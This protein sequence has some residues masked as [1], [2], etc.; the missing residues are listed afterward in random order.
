MFESLRSLGDKAKGAALQAG[1]KITERMNSLKDMKE[2]RS[3]TSGDYVLQP[4]DAV[5]FCGSDPV[6]NLIKKIQLH[7]TVPHIETPFQDLWT[8]AGILVDRTVLDLPC[9]EPGKMYLYESVFSGQVAGYVYSRVLPLDHVTPVGGNHLGPQIRDFEAVVNEGESN[10]AVCPLTDEQRRIVQKK[11]AENPRLILDIYEQ[12]FEF[13]YPITNLLS[14]IASASQ[15]LY[16]D[17]AK[18]NQ[19]A[20]SFFP[21]KESSKDTV[22]CSELVSIVYKSLG[23]P[24]FVNKP[25]D[26]FTPLEVQTAIEFGNV[27]VYAKENKV[28]LLKPGNKVTSSGSFLTNSQRLIKSFSLHD[29]WVQMPPSGGVPAGAE[30]AG[31]DVDGSNLFIARVRI[32][33]VYYLGKIA[34]DWKTPCVTY[35]GREVS[36]RFGHEV[37]TSLKGMKWVDAADGSVPAS[38]VK[39]G[40][41]EE[42]RFLYVCRGLVGGASGVLGVG[43]KEGCYAPGTVAPH[44]K[45][46]KIAFAGKEV[47]LAKYQ[48]LCY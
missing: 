11:L 21:Q 5:V 3:L 17:L 31:V 12:H 7:E 45:A 10:V 13:G 2:F 26:T 41:D 37:L 22:F 35:F 29:E 43:K 24:S 34:Q 46:A 18:F 23:L 33:E 47:S 15:S 9:M 42:S 40:I 25:S 30:P 20:S 36:I 8:H 14:V 44:L 27:V 4:L 39:A 16:N 1:S 32:G 19:L 48:V 38:A 28:C 6:A